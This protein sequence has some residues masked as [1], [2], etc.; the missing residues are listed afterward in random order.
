MH[1]P[2]SARTQHAAVK[3]S[4]IVRPHSPW[5]AQ[6]KRGFNPHEFFSPRRVSAHF[7]A[8]CNRAKYC[9]CFFRPAFI[10]RRF[11]PFSSSFSF[12]R[13]TNQ[14]IRHRVKYKVV[15]RTD[16]SLSIW[17]RRENIWNIRSKPIVTRPSSIALLLFLQRE[18]YDRQT[19]LKT[20]LKRMEINNYRILSKKTD[21]AGING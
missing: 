17:R 18:W 16:L 11:F 5:F 19:I 12:F 10:R 9:L 1:V 7:H 13:F 14:I 2:R 4:F 6:R 20:I 21:E 15:F 8:G 3:T